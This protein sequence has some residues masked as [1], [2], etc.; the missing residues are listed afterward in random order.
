[1]FCC[2]MRWSLIFD[3][4]V[5]VIAYRPVYVTGILAGRIGLAE[6]SKLFFTC[7]SNRNNFAYRMR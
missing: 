5:H 2:S 1:M 6:V 3:K 7:H 4:L